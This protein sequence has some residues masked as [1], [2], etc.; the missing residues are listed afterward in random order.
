MKRSLVVGKANVGK[1][2]FCIHFARYMGMRELRLLVQ[3]ADGRTDCRRLSVADAEASLSDAHPHRTRCLQS[4]A[5]EFPSGKTAR[6]LL[7]TDTTGLVAGIHPDGPLRESMA[8]TLQA[9]M[10]AD[11]IL[12]MVDAGAI[13][14]GIA[15][16]EGGPAGWD[17]LEEQI[18]SFGLRRGGYVI[19]A[20]KMDLSG[21]LD[22]YRYLCRRYSKQRVL[23]ISALHG[24]GFREVKRVVWR[25]A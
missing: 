9:M 8:Q 15:G 14:R 20:N 2:L 12:H 1:T 6:Q 5:L 23:P 22:G 19:L 3:E 10:D 18:A 4:I 24:T 13:G 21:A 16:R 11:L 17:A 7:L 25:F